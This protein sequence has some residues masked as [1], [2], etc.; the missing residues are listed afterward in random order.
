MKKVLYFI[1]FIFAFL[2]TSCMGTKTEITTMEI[3]HFNPEEEK[4]G[5]L[6]DVRTPDEFKSGHLPGAIN[7]DVLSDDFAEKMSELNKKG[8]V[9]VYCKS[10]M[11]SAKA[12]A[13][14]DTLGFRHIYNLDEK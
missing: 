4:K 13:I 3:I 14:M 12:T 10:G 9:Y 8:H 5:V 11:R 6:I 7:I 2:L 1:A